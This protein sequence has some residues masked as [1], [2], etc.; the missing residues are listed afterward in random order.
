MYQRGWSKL[1]TITVAD[2]GNLALEGV[3]LTTLSINVIV[4][5]AAKVIWV[6]ERAKSVKVAISIIQLIRLRKHQP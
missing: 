1:I 6:E 5:V 3:L 2:Q 4:D